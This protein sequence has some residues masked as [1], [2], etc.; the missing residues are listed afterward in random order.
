MDHEE[1]KFRERE[2]A[3]LEQIQRGIWSAVIRLDTLIILQKQKPH[4]TKAR[5]IVMPKSIQVGQTA[6]ITLQGFDQNGQPFPLDASYGVQYSAS[7]PADVEFSAP[8]PDGS[9][10]V[11]GLAVD[12]ADAIGATITRPD[13]VVI[14][15]NADAL[16]ITAPPAVLTSASVVLA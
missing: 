5:I 8:G 3:L 15:A 2:I 11:K 1:R 4:L 6:N 16:S 12:A 13:G 7:T 14:T 9:G 10:T